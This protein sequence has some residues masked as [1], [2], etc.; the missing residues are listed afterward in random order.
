MFVSSFLL[1]LVQGFFYGWN[2]L[3][4][5]LSII[6]GTILILI[7]LGVSDYKKDSQFL[8]F[9]DLLRDQKVTVIRGKEE[10]THSISAWDL[11]VGDVI[12]LTSGDKVPVDCLVL[13]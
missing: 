9:Q 11:V 4:Q 7:I 2:G 10:E 8:A 13:K 12:I 3:I 5:G 6:I 1:T